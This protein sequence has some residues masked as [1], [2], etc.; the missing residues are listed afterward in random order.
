MSNLI[1]PAGSFI[2]RTEPLSEEMLEKTNP[3][4]LVVCNAR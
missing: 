2:I 4:E 3:G 1:F